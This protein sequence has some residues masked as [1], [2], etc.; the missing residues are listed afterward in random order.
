MNLVIFWQDR[1]T[2]SFEERNWIQ[3]LIEAPKLYK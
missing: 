1:K 2:F 3:N